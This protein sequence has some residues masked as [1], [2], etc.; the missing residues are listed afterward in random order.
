MAGM[1]VTGAAMASSHHGEVYLNPTIPFGQSMVQ[2]YDSHSPPLPVI[3]RLLAFTAIHTLAALIAAALHR[4]LWPSSHQYDGSLQCRST[5]CA[6][7]WESHRREY[8]EAGFDRVSF[9]DA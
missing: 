9:L 5:S 2:L 1:V 4:L 3:V 8:M 7:L 6:G